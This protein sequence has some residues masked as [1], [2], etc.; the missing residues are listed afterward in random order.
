MINMSDAVIVGLI[1]FVASILG[2]GLVFFISWR[3]AP[4]EIAKAQGEAG[5]AEA[6]AAETWAKSNQLAAQQLVDMQQDLARVRT[7]LDAE[8]KSRQALEAQVSQHASRIHRLEAQVIS[9]G[10]EPV[11]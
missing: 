9:L 4:S 6:N 5:S 10:A 8:K 7:E 3:K 1:A 2:S 11:K